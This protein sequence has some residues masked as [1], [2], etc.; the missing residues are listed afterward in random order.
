LTGFAE[1]VRKSLKITKQFFDY[2][3]CKAIKTEKKRHIST[4]KK[5]YSLEDELNKKLNGITWNEY[6][7]LPNI[8]AQTE[9]V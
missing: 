9:S 2:L 6:S 3:V 5:L 1:L 4:C 8:A 7:P